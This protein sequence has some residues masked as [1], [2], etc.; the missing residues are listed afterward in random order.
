MDTLRRHLILGFGAFVAALAGGCAT[1]EIT[2]V[3]RDPDLASVPF[4]KVLVVFQHSDPRLRQALERRMA[5][6]IPNAVPA[7]AIF[8]DEEVRDI[9]KVKARVREQ[10]FDSSVIMRIVGVDRE[11]TYRP[12]RLY[13]VPGFYRGFY[14]YWGYGWRTVYDPGF[15]R[16][17]R[18]VTI[19]TNVYSVADD[20]LVWASQSETFNPA[21]LREAVGE[22]LRVTSKATGE[23]LKARG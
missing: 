10:G 22:V 7:H 23:V 12:G 8:S 9:E 5:A 20:K 15:Y 16:N 3:F 19:A 1:T 18:I 2:S 6:E 17:D 4:R 21:S 14:G 11:V 13:H